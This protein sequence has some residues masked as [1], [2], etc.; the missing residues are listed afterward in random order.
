M[1]LA[2]VLVRGLS[3]P[4]VHFAAVG[5][6]V[7][8]ADHALRP[9]TAAPPVDSRHRIEVDRAFVDGLVARERLASGREP[10]R[11]EV[12]ERWVRQE[13]LAREATNL[14]LD[15][16][17][18]PLRRRRAQLTELW[19]A[20]SFDLPEPSADVLQTFL[21]AHPDRYQREARIRLEHVFISG[22]RV[23][24]E[25]EATRAVTLLR[26]GVTPEDTDPFLLGAELG[27]RTQAELA[28]TFGA[29]WAEEVMTLNPGIWSAPIESVY[30]FHSVRILTTQPVEPATLSEVRGRVRADWQRDQ[31]DRRARLAYRHLRARYVVVQ[32]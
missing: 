24:A 14:G 22:E 29:S 28:H 10:D 30:G 9:G 31:A 17:D 5:L 3:E 6:L 32:E 4:L 7:F 11:E 12:L 26:A 8:G 2:S 19:L 21:E 23:N 13:V 15:A 16:H 18:G 27:P 1:S 20:S 25:L